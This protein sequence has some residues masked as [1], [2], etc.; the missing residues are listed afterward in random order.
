MDSRSTFLQEYSRRLAYSVAEIQSC[1]FEPIANC[2]A[3]QDI[4]Y[5]LSVDRTHLKVLAFSENLATATGRSTSEILGRT[6]DELLVTDNSQPFSQDTLDAIRKRSFATIGIRRPDGLALK[7]MVSLIDAGEVIHLELEVDVPREHSEYH[8][9]LHK[10]ISQLESSLSLEQDCQ[11]ACEAFQAIAGFD[12]VMAYRFQDNWDGE[13]IAEVCRKGLD[14]YLGLRYPASDIPRQAR[15]LY[16]KMPYRMIIDTEALPVPIVISGSEERRSI[17]LAQSNLR[18][19]SPIHIEYL[20]NMGVRSSFSVAIKVHN[21]LWGLISC[22]QY[23][24]PVSLPLKSRS[25]LELTGRILSG[26]IVNYI[27]RRRLL[28]RKNSLEFSQ[29]FIQNLTDGLPTKVSFQETKGLLLNLIQSSGAFIRLQGEDIHL[30][31]TTDMKTIEAIM[32][33]A[34]DEAGLGIWKSSSLKLDLDLAESPTGAAGAIVV[35]FSFGFDDVI[36]WF[37]PEAT[38]EVSW[39][40]DPTKLSN[41]VGRLTPR[42]SFAAWVETVRDRSIPWSEENEESAQFL[43]F[44]FVKGIFSKA[45]ALS[46]ANRELERVTRAKDEFIGMVSHELRTPLS[47]IIGWLDIL[48]DSVDSD[49]TE[50]LEAVEVIDRNAKLQI[51]L[52]NDLLDISRIISGKMRL[53]LASHVNVGLIGRDVVESLRPASMAKSI[54]LYY[55]NDAEIT[56]SVDADRMRQIIWNLVTNAIKFTPMRGQVFVSIQKKESSYRIEVKDTGVGLDQ[57]NLKTIFDRFSQVEAIGSVK[58]GLGLGLSIVKSL[59]ELHGGLVDAQSAGVGTGATFIVEMPIFALTPIEEKL[60]K[61]SQAHSLLPAVLRNKRVLIAEDQRDTAAA[62]K[63]LLDKMGAECTVCYDGKT[64]L[65]TLESNSFDLIISDVG[66]PELN[67]HEL[68]RAWRLQERL[69]DKPHTPAIAL[70]AYATSKDRTA[71]LESG[72]QSHI[73][74]P[75]DKAELIAVIESLQLSKS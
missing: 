42:A 13:V 29:A 24:S 31:Q 65:K 35:P 62:L 54:Q 55:H 23:G 71:A 53:S 68:L 47:A 37:R 14:P 8:D 26:R 17:Q 64:A 41:N 39:G 46:H 60:T 28:A 22:H 32:G 15:E 7:C 58:G 27:E 72:F 74:K 36:I 2:G 5:F 3:I 19:S 30:G 34:R 69:H 16:L 67:G 1:E 57:K 59:V 44:H 40:G 52:I 73:P 6:L 4:G 20:L 63:H 9:P 45:A 66:M 33:K 70:T 18:A 11:L 49:D 10:L 50:V 48:K 75:V 43:L 56:A 25:S 12:R 21:K 38:Q 61:H 51:T